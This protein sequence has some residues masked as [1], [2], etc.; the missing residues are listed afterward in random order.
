MG[1]AVRV[2]VQGQ[3]PQWPLG[4]RD[5]THYPHTCSHTSISE[6]GLLLGLQLGGVASEGWQ[7]PWGVWAWL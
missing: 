7:G 2:S 1:G 5:L 4:T 6:L 3:S